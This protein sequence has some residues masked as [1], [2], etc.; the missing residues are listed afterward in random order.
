MVDR[1]YLKICH[2]DSH[3]TR[4]KT[5]SFCKENK[6]PSLTLKG[7]TP[8]GA[9][10]KANSVRVQIVVIRHI[11]DRDRDSIVYKVI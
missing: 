4:V 2:S 3:R 10:R 11:E 1:D 8:C 9:G 7:T 6:N 5:T